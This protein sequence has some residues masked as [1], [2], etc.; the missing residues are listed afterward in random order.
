MGAV[1]LGGEDTRAGTGAENAKVEDKQQA[2]DD[3]NTAHGNGTH[4][5]HHDVVQQGNK[6]G[7][8]VLNDDGNGHRKT[9]AVKRPVA[10]VTFEHRSSK[11][12]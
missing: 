4:L 8:A 5:A 7:D 1:E 9:A 6:I 11:T 3:G 12:L 2:V 10:D